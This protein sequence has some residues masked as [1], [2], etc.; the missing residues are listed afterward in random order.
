SS[1]P[2][3][4]VAGKLI[5]EETF[6]GNRPEGR[7]RE[8]EK[9]QEL[10]PGAV[11]LWDHCFELPGQKLD[12]QRKLPDS[13]LVGR[14]EH[15]LR[16]NGTTDKLELYDYPGGFADRFDGVAPGGGDR[17]GDLAKIFED[18]Q[19]T[20]GIRLEQEAVEALTARG[21]SDCGQMT[22]GHTFTLARHFD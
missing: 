10:C 18:N 6:G 13:V 1:H 12:A 2:E 9:A 8:W 15:K 22:A 21:A 20:A 19:R 17:A 5:Y 3:L 14:V 11:T 16:L 4:P 7:V